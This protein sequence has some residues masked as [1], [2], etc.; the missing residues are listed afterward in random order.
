MIMDSGA[1]TSMT[2]HKHLLFDYQSLTS[3]SKVTASNGGTLQAIGKGKIILPE[4][5]SITI[6]NVLDVPNL[7]KTLLSTDSITKQDYTI[8]ISEDMNIQTKK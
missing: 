1:N 3:P 2:Q 4:K 6:P 7:A 5:T 8:T